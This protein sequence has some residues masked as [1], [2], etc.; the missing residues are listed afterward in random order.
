MEYPFK[1]SL[2]CFNKTELLKHSEDY[3]DIHVVKIA[4]I[5]VN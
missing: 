5:S 2:C 3:V 4:I 1:D